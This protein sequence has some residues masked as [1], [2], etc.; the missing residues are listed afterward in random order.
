MSSSGGWGFGRLLQYDPTELETELAKRGAVIV[1]V[2][3]ETQIVL[4]KLGPE[5]A[6]PAGPYLGEIH[7]GDLDP[8]SVRA[9]SLSEIMM[10][11]VGELARMEHSSARSSAAAE[12]PAIR[13]VDSAGVGHRVQLAPVEQPGGIEANVLALVFTSEADGSV[14]AVRVPA[15]TRIEALGRPAL[16]ELLSRA[17]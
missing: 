14:R 7:H 12:V 9:I 11:V 6:D 4:R 3:P 16:D 10:R 15:D 8:V 2:T 13:H 1:D 17:G 5:S